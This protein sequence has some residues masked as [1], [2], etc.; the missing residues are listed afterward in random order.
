MR[1]RFSVTLVKHHTIMQNNLN[2]YIRIL[3]LQ[4]VVSKHKTKSGTKF[5]TNR[6]KSR[7]INKKYNDKT[8]Y[9]YICK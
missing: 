6:V 8:N 4:I 3:N 7:L 9:S 5:V 2:S 1:K